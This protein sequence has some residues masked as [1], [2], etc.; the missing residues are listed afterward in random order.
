MR[1]GQEVGRFPA[2]ASVTEHSPLLSWS[3][4]ERKRMC[5]SE[6][7]NRPHSERLDGKCLMA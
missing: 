5:A 3:M 6:G 4:G 1:L 2:P 7:Y